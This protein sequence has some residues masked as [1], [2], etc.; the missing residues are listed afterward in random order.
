MTN[1]KSAPKAPAFIKVSASR[2]EDPM[3]RGYDPEMLYVECSRCGSPVLW[4]PGR[5]TALV[6]SAGIDPLELDATC[7]LVTD[8]C[9][10]CSGQGH[11]TVQMYRLSGTPSHLRPPSQGNA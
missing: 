5:A 4:E 2:V 3:H 1:I 7:M 6:R 8:G 9:P 11:Y 10:V